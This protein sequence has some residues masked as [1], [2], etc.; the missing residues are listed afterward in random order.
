M[1][2]PPITKTNHVAHDY[3]KDTHFP[4]NAHVYSLLSNKCGRGLS[5]VR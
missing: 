5:D 4:P 1:N 3:G 2:T